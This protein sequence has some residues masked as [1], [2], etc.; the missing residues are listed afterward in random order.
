MLALFVFSNST[1]VT[2]L[3]VSSQETELNT[4]LKDTMRERDVIQL[5][6]SW[7]QIIVSHQKLCGALLGQTLGPVRQNLINFSLF[8][9]Q[10]GRFLN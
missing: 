6:D 10:L 7:Y 3:S 5:V 8:L 1:I 4:L 9:F 2:T